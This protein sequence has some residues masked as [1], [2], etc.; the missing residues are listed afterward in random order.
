ML[1]DIYTQYV[2][3]MQVYSMQ[4]FLVL[5]LVVRPVLKRFPY[6]ISNIYTSL[7]TFTTFA[8]VAQTHYCLRYISYL[9]PQSCIFAS[10]LYPI[11][12]DPTNMLIE[13]CGTVNNIT[14]H[15]MYVPFIF[16][17]AC[18][19]YTFVFVFNLSKL[20]SYTQLQMHP[21][22]FCYGSYSYIPL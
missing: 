21:Y 9:R 16:Y 10:C 8:N 6:G 14:N 1:H 4:C 2:A 11:F 13:S 17:S 15:C 7:V 20:S 19:G 22:C 12:T 5:L 18:S 3:A